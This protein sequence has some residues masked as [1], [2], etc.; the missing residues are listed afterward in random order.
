MDH[1]KRG[2]AVI[3]YHHAYD[4]Q[5]YAK[6]ENSLQELDQLSKLLRHLSFELHV[7][8]DYSRAQ[9]I[10][11]IDEQVEADHSNAD[12]FF[13]A[14]LTHGNVGTVAARDGD[15]SLKAEFDKFGDHRCKSLRGKPKIFYIMVKRITVVASRSSG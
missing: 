4:K 6:R 10:Q 8:R 3:F 11:A 15:I 13:L 9:V 5:R 2:N 12:C 14:F 7:F 1:E